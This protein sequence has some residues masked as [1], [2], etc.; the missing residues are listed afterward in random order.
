MDSSHQYPADEYRVN[1]SARSRR[2]D[3]HQKNGLRGS[4]DF[5]NN[6]LS[7]IFEIEGQTYDVVLTDTSITWSNVA[8]SDKV[9]KLKKKQSFFKKLV[10][11]A[12]HK[13][14]YRRE[15]TDCINLDEILGAAIHRIRRAGQP[16]GQGVCQIATYVVINILYLQGI[17]LYLFEYRGQNKWR[18]RI[19]YLN[20]PSEEMCS[21]FVTKIQSVIQ[22]KTER[23]KKTRIFLQH[24]SGKKNGRTI[25]KEKIRPILDASGNKSELTEILNDGDISRYFKHLNLSEYDSML[26]IGGDG[27]VNQVVTELISK[28]Q[29]EC[30]K[31]MRIDRN[32]I[33]CEIPLGVIPIGTTNQVANSVIGIDDVISSTIQFVLGYK[34]LVD[35]MSVWKDD[36][37][38]QCAF[39]AH[40][41]FFGMV[42]KYFARF[43]VLGDKKIELSVGKALSQK[44]FKEYEC[45][46]EYLPVEPDRLQGH[47]NEYCRQGCTQCIGASPTTPRTSRYSDAIEEL[48][49]LN[50]SGNSS[51]IA[52]SACQDP[53]DSSNTSAMFMTIIIPISTDLYLMNGLLFPLDLTENA[54]DKWKHLKGSFLNITLLSIPAM[55]RLA[56]YGINQFGHLGDGIMDLIVV[57]GTDRR[58]F[59]RYLK[60]HGSEKNALTLPFI[61]HF[62]CSAV[63]VVA[64]NRETW[65][66]KDYSYHDV[67]YSMEQQQRMA[68]RKQSLSKSVDVID[69]I[70]DSDDDDDSDSEDYS[71]P[72]S[73]SSS[74]RSVQSRND[75]QTRT[76][77]HSVTS[78]GW[79][80]EE[81]Q[82]KNANVDMFSAKQTS[83]KTK[84]RRGSFT[85]GGWTNEGCEI[86]DEK[87]PARMSRRQSEK[88]PP[89][90]SWNG[91]LV[92]ISDR[93]KSEQPLPINLRPTFQDQNRRRLARKE[94]KKSERRRLKA[95]RKARGLWALDM[96]TKG[97]NDLE[98]R[99]HNG[100]LSL[101]GC[102]VCYEYDP[103]DVGFGCLALF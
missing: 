81:R 90:K 13:D 35:V 80:A 36:R 27:T 22:G 49:P 51:T 95:E 85:Q 15:P 76:Q 33:R 78:N 26:V 30:G 40:Y 61:D 66:H 57:K 10:N 77:R 87:E 62:K 41:G 17:A 14:D 29:I 71:R 63:R 38:L 93:R 19:V 101:S 56:P 94:R 3:K 84:E 70:G 7:A 18:E 58:E 37:F 54:D 46:I 50:Q 11:A 83:N 55:S 53:F 100:I 52:N 74:R 67:Q 24:F 99:I 69:E 91:S 92:N 16:E 9:P 65:N 2:R 86:N 68:Q 6:D 1:K 60:R 8:G 12:R 82:R 64:R 89:S 48:D 25:F 88:K 103:D 34:R 47:R 75:S 42:C 39:T 79:T 43:S 31:E 28:T 44:K 97:E 5:E 32:P 102:G 96:T 72:P 45:E 73:R 23:P 4:Y 98:F 20:H 59:V 21:K